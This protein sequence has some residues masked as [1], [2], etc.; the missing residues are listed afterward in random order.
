[1]GE[2]QAQ[3]VAYLV[4]QEEKGFLYAKVDNKFQRIVSPTT[5][6]SYVVTFDNYNEML[7]DIDALKRINEDMICYHEQ[8]YT[9]FK[10]FNFCNL[11]SMLQTQ[12]RF[13]HRLCA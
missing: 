1:M 6:D 7:G 13:E 4:N 12:G 5:E 8:N 2:T 11:I 3:F 10:D 9:P